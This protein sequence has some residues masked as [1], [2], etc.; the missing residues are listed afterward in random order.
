[1]QDSCF[2]PPQ[3]WRVAGVTGG[4]FGVEWRTVITVERPAITVVD[5]ATGMD[6][7]RARIALDSNENDLPGQIAGDPQA[8]VNPYVEPTPTISYPVESPIDLPGQATAVAKKILHQ[9]DATEHIQAPLGVMRKGDYWVITEKVVAP[10]GVKERY[11][12][13]SRTGAAAERLR[14]TRN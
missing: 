3:S 11:L 13:L 12:V 4:S 9:L 6:P 10:G 7:H 14:R 5:S 8:W 1:M 2:G